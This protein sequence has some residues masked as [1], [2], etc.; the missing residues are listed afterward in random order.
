MHILN[1]KDEIAKVL[2][3]FVRTNAWIGVKTESNF[4]LKWPIKSWNECQKQWNEAGLQSQK[5]HFAKLFT[6][7]W[8][9]L[10]KLWGFLGD[11]HQNEAVFRF[12]E[13]DWY[14]SSNHVE[15]LVKYFIYDHS[16]VFNRWNSCFRYLIRCFGKHSRHLSDRICKLT[17]LM[18]PCEGSLDA[19]NNHKF[20]IAICLCV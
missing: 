2:Y 14:A 9:A 20:L 3:E 13:C 17:S 10:L 19:T 16:M 1:N 8:I 11:F 15:L 4:V 12:G 5:H 18:Y 6:D 7:L